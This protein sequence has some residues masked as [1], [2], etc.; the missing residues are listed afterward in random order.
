MKQL[1]IPLYGIPV[2]NHIG[3]T[4]SHGNGGGVSLFISDV[5]IYSELTELSMVSDY[6]ERIFVKIM[7]NDL[8]YVIG[9]MYRP[10]N[11]NIVMFNE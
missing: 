10:P 3:I 8:S 1:N 9:V 11:S 6:I 7:H 2:Y 4:R 5:F